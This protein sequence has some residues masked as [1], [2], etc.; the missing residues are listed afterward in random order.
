MKTQYLVFISYGHG[1]HF[2]TVVEKVEG[3]INVLENSCD[4]ID[5]EVLDQVAEKTAELKHEKNFYVEFGRGTWCTITRMDFDP[6]YIAVPTA[7]IEGR[8]LNAVLIGLRHVQKYGYIEE[9]LDEEMPLN[10]DEIDNLCIMLNTFNP[11]EKDAVLSSS[12]K[13]RIREMAESVAVSTY[14]CDDNPVPYNDFMS[15]EDVHEIAS[16][17]EPFQHDNTDIIQENVE[18]EADSLV[19]FANAIINTMT[20]ND[21]IDIIGQR[22]YDAGVVN[23]RGN[24]CLTSIHSITASQRDT[25]ERCNGASPVNDGEVFINT[26]EYDGYD[27]IV[28]N[29]AKFGVS[30]VLAV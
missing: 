4:E 6:E 24:I 18:N 28:K 8:E 13:D 1:A 9:Y 12:L 2:N 20:T 3:V 29:A 25:A 22:A 19:G 15:S 5:Q 17:W 26:E 7:G 21:M 16:I 14:T 10:N 11:A 23:S 30:Y 27:E